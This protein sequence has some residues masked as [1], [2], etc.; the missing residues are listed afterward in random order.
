MRQTN[1]YQTELMAVLREESKRERAA[2]RGGSFSFVGAVKNKIPRKIRIGLED[3][4]RE[5]FVM[6]FNDGTFVIEQTYDRKA[7]ERKHRIRQY[8]I[9]INGE[10]DDLQRLCR[11]SA[12]RNVLNATVTAAEGIGLGL[13]GVGIPDIILFL[14]MLLRGIYETAI[15]YGYDYRSSSE[16]YFILKMMETVL[17]RGDARKAGHSELNRMITEQTVGRMTIKDMNDQ[18]R[19][20]SSA[21]ASD[22]IVLKF[23]QGVPIV[24]AIGGIGNPVYYQK[25]MRYVRLMYKKRYL[26]EHSG[27]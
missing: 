21:F 8:I 27:V 24:G 23:I 4:F 6:I 3:V 19:K 11:A 22:M 2:C 26:C 16:K 13:L 12:S 17:L 1:V 18:I 5:V 9:D 10:Q 14:G 15:N 25:V 20:T 7:M